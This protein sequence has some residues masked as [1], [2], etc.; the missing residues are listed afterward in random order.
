MGK[1]QGINAI[2]PILG[3]KRTMAPALVDLL[4]DGGRIKPAMYYEPFHG[5]M[6]VL[7]ELRGRGFDGVAIV[8]DKH[9]LLS[10][11]A[12]CLSDAKAVDWLIR[13]LAALPFHE[14]FFRQACMRLSSTMTA[15]RISAMRAHNDWEA[16]LDYLA[17]SWMQRNG[18]AGTD[19]ERNWAQVMQGFCVRYS[20]S[21]GDPAVRWRSV[22]ESVPDW[23]QALCRKTTFTCRDAVE[24]LK[25]IDDD[26]GLVIYL[27]P[28]YLQET[29]S[30][31][32]LVDV[33]DGT[34]TF[35]ESEDF[36]S[37]LAAAVR[38]FTA[39]RVALS[40]YAHE[41]LRRLF[42]PS[43]GWR[44]LDAARAKHLSV[45]AGG[46]AAVAPELVIT[47]FDTGLFPSVTPTGIGALT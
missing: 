1:G 11:L 24:Q 42:P 13:Q 9:G 10:N 5:S 23:Y 22:I 15:G 33:E 36:Y 16:A 38:K 12:R 30:A 8:N 27:D 45:T 28:P 6:A 37:Q 41:R 39:A 29:R 43:D 34:G 31:R 4:T 2:I 18:E 7:L 3:G 25:A 47:N 21:G 26:A 32:Y 46:E 20:T 40:F 19:K 14:G 17:V 35:Y 44:H